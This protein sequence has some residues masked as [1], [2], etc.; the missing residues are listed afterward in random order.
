[1]N[2]QNKLYYIFVDL[3]IVLHNAHRFFIWKKVKIT[4]ILVVFYYI[5]NIKKVNSLNAVDLLR[6]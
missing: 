6:Y 2:I 5:I 1:M 3:S 4:A